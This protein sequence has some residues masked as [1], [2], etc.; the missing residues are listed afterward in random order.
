[1]ALAIPPRDGPTEDESP[2]VEVLAVLRTQP[3]PEVLQDW[4]LALTCG[5]FASSLTE[6]K[7]CATN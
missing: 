4:E 3:E 6:E 7:S 5:L 1:M 2:D